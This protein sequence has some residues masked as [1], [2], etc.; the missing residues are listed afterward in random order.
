MYPKILSELI[1]SFK[2]FPGIGEKTAERLAF[3]VLKLEQEQLDSLGNNLKNVKKL[4][5]NC[6]KCNLLSQNEICTIC[7]DNKREKNKLCIVED[8]KSVFSIEKIGSYKGYYFILNGLINSFEGINIEDLRLDRL[9][10]NI[11]E[12]DYDEI[13]IAV[14]PCI[15]GEMTALYIKSILEEK[16][17]KITRLASGIPMGADM[18]YIDSLTLERAFENRKIIS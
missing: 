12:S 14:K 6:K 9:I 3:S 4:L 8:S 7:S 11:E 1:E 13:I 18:D 17:I 16:N 15:E 2:Y 10:K 5:K